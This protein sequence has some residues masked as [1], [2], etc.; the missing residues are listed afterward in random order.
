M[1]LIASNNGR[2]LTM[3]PRTRAEHARFLA[4]VQANQANWSEVSRRNNPR[5]KHKP[6]VVYR[7]V[8]DSAGSQE[9]YRILW[10]HSSQKQ[11]RDCQA[12]L[13]KLNK[14]SKRLRRL[15]PPGRGEGFKTEQAAREAAQ[16]VMEKAKV[17]DWLAVVI[18][19]VVRV[20]HVQVG[21]G[22]PGPNTRYKLVQ[23]KSYKVNVER[24]EEALR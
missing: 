17:Q 11:E 20:E 13:K 8:E 24:N 3:M 10:Y 21:R 7:A 1:P 15:R 19:E 23:I 6:P 18:E 4:W 5:G 2:F 14:A 12:R 16:R 22:R 9:G